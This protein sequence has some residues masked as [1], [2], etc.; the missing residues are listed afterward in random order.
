[1]TCPVKEPHL[2]I[3]EL[4]PIWQYVIDELVATTLLA[5][6]LY[7]D[8]YPMGVVPAEDIVVAWETLAPI[9]FDN[10]LEAEAENA[11]IN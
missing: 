7:T 6:N 8:K 1:M 3:N 10:W 2:C 5:G 11:V 4:P 9:L